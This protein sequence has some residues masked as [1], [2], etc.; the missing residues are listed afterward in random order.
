MLKFSAAL[1]HKTLKYG[2]KEVKNKI[3]ALCNNAVYP[4][5]I[6]GK[7]QVGAEIETWQRLE[8]KRVANMFENSRKNRAFALKRSLSSL[9]RTANGC[10]T[11]EA[12][13]FSLFLREVWRAR[14]PGSAVTPC[15]LPQGPDGS[16]ASLG[17]A[18]PR[19][20]CSPRAPR[21]PGG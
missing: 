20:S 8:R 7:P 13:E 1:M 15:P 10:F 3:A 9:L 21:P 12:L 19:G 16:S 18:V 14:A 2:A 11:W 4:G 5:N 6:Q 17:R